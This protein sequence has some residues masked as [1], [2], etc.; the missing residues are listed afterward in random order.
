MEAVGTRAH[1]EARWRS[2]NVT[3]HRSYPKTVRE[4]EKQRRQFYLAD[5]SIHIQEEKNSNQQ[6]KVSFDTRY[7]NRHT[8]VCYQAWWRIESWRVSQLWQQRIPQ[9]GGLYSSW[10][11]MPRLQ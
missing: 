11:R 5:V 1:F 7:E 6:K 8:F 4:F 2:Q 3:P 10:K 9:E